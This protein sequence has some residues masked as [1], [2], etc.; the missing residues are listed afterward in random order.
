VVSAL[1]G[2]TFLGEQ[3]Q[4]QALGGMALVITGGLVVVIGGDMRQSA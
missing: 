1:L 4:P 2:V 3:P